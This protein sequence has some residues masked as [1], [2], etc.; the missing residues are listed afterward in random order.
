MGG[1]MG[2][3]VMAPPAP[4][5]GGAPRTD[6]A[7]SGRRMPSWRSLSP[8]PFSS[9]RR[10]TA[11]PEHPAHLS[12]AG[13]PP[14]GPRLLDRVR[15]PDTEQG[16]HRQRQ[17]ILVGMVA[18]V[19]LGTSLAVV[20]WKQVRDTTPGRYIDPSLQPDEPGFVALVTPTPT[21]LVIHRGGDGALAGVS[22]LSLRSGDDG[23]SVIVMP[24]ATRVS[25]EEDGTLASAY[26][27]GGAEAVGEAVEQVLN[28]AVPTPVELDD[29]A[30]SGMLAP[31]DP[32]PIQLD[33]PVGYWPAGDVALPADEV[34][35]FLGARNPGESE[36]SR[37]SRQEQFWQ[38]W[39]DAVANGGDD[40]V[41]G[42]DDV[43]LGRFLRGLAGGSV[44]VS[45]LPVA[46]DPQLAEESFL[47]DEALVPAL[48]ASDV[49]YPQEPSPGSRIR[50]RLLNGTSD[51]DL[52]L[53]AATSLV[54]AGAEIAMSGNADSFRQRRT[55]F[56]YTRDDRRDEATRL[57][58]A[59]G[60]GVVEASE[61][62]E[63]GE[64][65][66]GQESE[67]VDVTVI[68]GADALDAIRR[69]ESTD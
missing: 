41:P 19:L 26:A 61:V 2:G 36:L 24:A 44:M 66:P 18:L 25:A 8:A 48:V 51:G 42:E 37:L 57:R 46:Q 59:F 69:S 28:V 65:P 47:P 29:A 5:P 10:S 52:N 45:S 63:E 67:R 11:A 32:L 4:A 68:L 14:G 6:G 55:R 50:V 27:A 54:E 20:G 31:V 39:L 17:L 12:D 35:G 7:R 13:S 15:F 1:G 53:W 30:W 33:G 21:L 3:G 16:V 40:A 64:L 38:A 62:D 23:G 43:G 22:L 58:Q 9:R 60:F 49:P 34:G 56:V